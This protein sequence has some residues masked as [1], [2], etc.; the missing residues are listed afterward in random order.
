M[1]HL[2]WTLWILSNWNFF[3]LR[4]RKERICW[5]EIS[6]IEYATTATRKYSKCGCNRWWWLH[7][8]SIPWWNHLVGHAHRFHHTENLSWTDGSCRIVNFS[9]IFFLC[10]NLWSC[11]D[12]DVQQITITFWFLISKIIIFISDYLEKPI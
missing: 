11:K 3:F 8:W 4:K 9:S 7:E 6:R 1:C 12:F 10:L 5:V 2:V